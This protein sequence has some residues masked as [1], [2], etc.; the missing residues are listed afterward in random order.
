MSSFKLTSLNKNPKPRQNYRSW[1]YIQLFAIIIWSMQNENE[2]KWHFWT[3]GLFWNS[4]APYIYSQECIYIILVNQL[5]EKYP[6]GLW[7]YISRGFQKRYQACCFLRWAHADSGFGEGIMSPGI[8][9]CAVLWISHGRQSSCAP[10][11][12]QWGEIDIWCSSLGLT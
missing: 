2:C 12:S 3:C 4:R 10:L 7:V 11:S 5:K 8:R 6:F 1:S 9:D